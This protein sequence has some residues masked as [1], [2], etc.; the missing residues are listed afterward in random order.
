VRAVGLR[1]PNPRKQGDLGEAAA[2][3][4]LAQIGAVVCV[5]LFH[6]PDFDLVAEMDGN[7]ARVQVKT[8]TVKNGRGY[9]V[10]LATAGGNQSWTRIVKF[11]DP[12][13]FDYL[14]ALVADGRHWFIPSGVIEGRRAI[15][16]G[17]PKYSEFE[18]TDL[19]TGSDDDRGSL[20]RIA[21]PR[22]SAGAGEPGRPVKSV[23]LPEWVRFPP[24][25]SRSAGQRDGP[26]IGATSAVTRISRNH[27]LTIPK[28]PFL[29]A[30]LAAGDRMRIEV[31][32]SGSVHARRIES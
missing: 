6:S 24:P 17:G 16:V 15:N 4:W 20:S 32:G 19:K 29:A 9:A 28:R 30:G 1:Q 25:P 11:F 13:R 31:S 10:Q 8:S 7:L 2:I 26:E 22:G 27:Q 21:G 23:A 3:H 14:F 5:P 12:S 18:V